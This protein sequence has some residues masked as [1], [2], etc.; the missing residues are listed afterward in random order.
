M[1]EHPPY[2]DGIMFWGIG[3]TPVPLNPYGPGHVCRMPSY[4]L[5]PDAAQSH[6]PLWPL[7]TDLVSGSKLL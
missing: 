3:M 7:H 6:S 5:A 2:N 1:E 4:W